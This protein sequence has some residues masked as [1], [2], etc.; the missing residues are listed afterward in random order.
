MTIGAVV[1]SVADQEVPTPQFKKDG[2]REK[3]KFKEAKKKKE[4][5][6]YF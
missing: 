3:K 2:G 6:V 5:I 4:K 1:H